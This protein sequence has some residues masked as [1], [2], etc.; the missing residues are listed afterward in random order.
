MEEND[1]EYDLNLLNLEL[2]VMQKEQLKDNPEG[3]IVL[4]PGLLLILLTFGIL[5][6]L[7][8]RIWNIIISIL[9]AFTV[10]DVFYYIFRLRRHYK[11]DKNRY[12]KEI[13]E[14]DKTN[15]I[16][17]ISLYLV[18]LFL[19][20]APII[21]NSTTYNPIES[22]NELKAIS[23]EITEGL[24]DNDS[25]FHAILEWFDRG[26]GKQ[27]NISNV[28]YKMENCRQT[29][30]ELL[31]VSRLLGECYIYS[32]P[33][34]I[35]YRKPETTEKW[36][37]WIFHTRCGACGEYAELFNQMGCYANLTV[38]KAMCKGEDHVWN[39]VLI[40]DEWIIIDPTA[41]NLN[42]STGIMSSSFMEEKVLGDLRADGGNVSEGNVS[43][44]YAIY[45]DK[46]DYKEDITNRYTNVTNITISVVDDNT[47]PVEGA[48]IKVYSLN[49]LEE[50]YTDLHNTTNSSGKHTFTLGGGEY[51]FKA[52]KG[53]L[54]G[55]YHDSFSEE[56]LNHYKEIKIN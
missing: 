3:K 19:I 49:R 28:Y 48:E 20:I 9:I 7:S 50:R 21:I 11:N 45:P 30:N 12:N 14:F 47:N 31:F 43:Y 32:K 51:K 36:A 44:V 35:C 1:Y 38:R 15:L 10:V 54:Q 40:S 33:P 37:L 34:H 8:G 25:K 46:P 4:Y 26:V 52:S 16:L 22:E 24:P 18:T 13:K 41:V 53:D 42:K 23:R 39:E 29:D 17:I 27:E 5:T 56:L 6:S 2:N 55:E